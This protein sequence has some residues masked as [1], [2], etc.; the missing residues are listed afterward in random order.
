M[1]S[2]DNFYK[3]KRW[4][5][6]RQSV[7]RRDKYMCQWCKDQGKLVQAVDVHHIFPRDQ[8]PQYQW[9]PWN[10]KS[11]CRD[12]HNEMHN[13]Y[14]G[15]LSQ[16]GMNLLRA[17]A[18]VNHIPYRQ[19]KETIL[20]IGIRG[21][22]KSTYVKHHLDNYSM[23]YDMDA[24]ASAFRLKMPHEEY[25]R[26]A[27]MMANA[28]LFGFLAKAHEYTE[29]VYVIRTAPTIKELEQIKPTRVVICKHVYEYRKM[30][31][32]N[33][34]LERISEVEHYCTAQGLRVD[35]IS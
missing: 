16:K 1:P 10:L 7:L 30:D 5:L 32:R 13:H 31:D 18:I 4:E 24:I 23:A 9:Q 28:F 25:F 35:V 27:R 8:Y 17:T 3:T 34:A 11:L 14:N 6:L 20:V 21:T 19:M 2:K 33:A 22:G 29:C 12:C 15:Q 26:P